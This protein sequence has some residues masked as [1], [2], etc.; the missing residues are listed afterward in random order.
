MTSTFRPLHVPEIII[1]HTTV[2]TQSNDHE[3]LH[4]DVLLPEHKSV[5]IPHLAEK[6]GSS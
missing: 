2:Y 5:E 3:I 4:P 6:F 1:A